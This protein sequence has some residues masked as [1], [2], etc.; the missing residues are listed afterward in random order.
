MVYTECIVHII[1]V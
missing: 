1:S